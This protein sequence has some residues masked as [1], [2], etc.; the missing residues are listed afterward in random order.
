MISTLE[1]IGIKIFILFQKEPTS[2]M[3]EVGIGAPRPLVEGERDPLT[4]SWVI[5]LAGCSITG[6]SSAWIGI[7]K[8][9]SIIICIKNLTL[10]LRFNGWFSLEKKSLLG[11]VV[12]TWLGIDGVDPLYSNPAIPGKDT[13]Q[14]NN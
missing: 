3:I 14:E 8:I 12:V 6:I 10:C 2:R 5:S 11:E 7:M 4:A 1:S 13:V 9:F